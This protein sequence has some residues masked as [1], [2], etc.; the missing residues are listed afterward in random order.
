MNGAS[1]SGIPDSIPFSDLLF[2]L[3]MISPLL[4]IIKRE[5]KGF[6]LVSSG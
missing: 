4:L 5:I 2:V 1:N 6:P 3:S